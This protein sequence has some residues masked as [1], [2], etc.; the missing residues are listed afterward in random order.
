MRYTHRTERSELEVRLLNIEQ[1]VESL[2]R[3]VATMTDMLGKLNLIAA[4]YADHALEALPSPVQRMIHS[5]IP[6]Y[7]P[8]PTG[9]DTG[10]AQTPSTGCGCA[11]THPDTPI[12]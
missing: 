9:H 4:H 10:C 8:T 1:S 3:I 11:K 7:A 12:S 6:S 5:S 2:T